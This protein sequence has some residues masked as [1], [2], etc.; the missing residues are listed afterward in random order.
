MNHTYKR[1]ISIKYVYLGIIFIL[2]SAVALF[3][4]LAYLEINF[5]L[6][7]IIAYIT[8]M[9]ATFT[10]IYHSLSL[11]QRIEEQKYN[12]FLYKSKYTY[13]LISEW[14]S[15]S[16]M[17]SINCSRKLI[18]DPARSIEL[19]DK[20]KVH[21]FA[22]YLE[23]NLDERKH[24]ILILNYFENISTMINSKHVDLEIV[25]NAFK[26][27]FVSYYEHLENYIDFRQKEYPSS[28]AYFESIAKTWRQENKTA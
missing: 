3:I 14:H 27:M 18:K 26:S 28:W 9:T 10:L 1:D 24:L 8:G 11:E 21:L 17:D 6:I 20:T 5:G 23:K 22:D 19:R 12:N 4:L 16:M 2:L 7:E 15:P 25:K 13:D